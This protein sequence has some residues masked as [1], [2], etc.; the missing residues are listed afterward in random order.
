MGKRMILRLSTPGF[1]IMICLFTVFTS[2]KKWDD[3][4]ALT[5]DALNLNLLQQIQQNPQL[6]LF[7]EYLNKTGYDKVIASANIYTVWAP[8]NHA[9]ETLDAA[10][11]NDSL[12]LKLFIGNHI[13]QHA[14]YTKMADTLMRI[15]TLNGKY[16]KFFKIKLDDADITAA[17]QSVKNGVLH[18]VNQAAHPKP[19]IWEYVNSTN[20]KQKTYMLSLNYEAI[21]SA[22]GEQVGIDPLTG[23]PIYKP[24]SGLV[25]KNHLFDRTGY[26]DNEDQEYTFILLADAAIESERNKLKPYTHRNN[27]DSTETLA[28]LYVMKDLAFKGLYTPENLPDTLVSADGVKVPLDKNAIVE[29]RVTSNGIVYVMSKADVKLKD[30]ILPIKKE[31]ENPDGFSQSDKSSSVHYRLRKNPFTGQLFNDIY[32]YNHKVPLFNVRYKVPDVYSTTYKIYWVAPNDVQTV[33]FKQRFAI[34]NPISNEFNETTA[35]LKNYDEIY[36]GEYTAN[37]C[38][39]LNAYVIAANNGVDQTNSINIDYFKLVPQLP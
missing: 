3:H 6:S 38:G 2:C 8:D 14:Y 22:A 18:I 28:S 11:V 32:I 33:T 4:N 27:A 31:G 30:K 17:D 35:G 23:K 24:G 15:K 19:N 34:N 37:N 9:M 29:T 5:D 16:V 25:L 39:D 21:D 26:L 7:S 20:L 13:V 10:V 12:K 1:L 36:I